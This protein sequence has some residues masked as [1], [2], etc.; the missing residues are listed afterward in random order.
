MSA[1]PQP[2]LTIGQ[3]LPWVNMMFDYTEKIAATLTPELR[4]WRPT[5]PN[6]KFFFS[7]GELVAHSADARRMFGRQL[8][9]NQSE[10]DY[11]SSGPSEADGVWQFKPL[12]SPEQ[13]VASLK[14]AREELQPW[15][16]KPASEQWTATEGTQAVFAKALAQMK[17]AG[18]DTAEMEARGAANVNRI[19]FAVIAHESGHRAVLQTLLRMNGVDS[20][21][22]N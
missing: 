3:S 20:G 4:D 16:D 1:N 11:W 12:G 10:D 15:L 13:L 18:K 8:T 21:A 7:L 5:D 9:G 2:Q 6:G 17:E 22:E 19:L 14:S